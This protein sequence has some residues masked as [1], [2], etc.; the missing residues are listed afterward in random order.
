MTT[1]RMPRLLG[2]GVSARRKAPRGMSPIARRL[3]ARRPDA[4]KPEGSQE[5]HVEKCLDETLE[6]SFPASARRAGLS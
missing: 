6:E 2:G 3:Q 4:D 5:E 1:G